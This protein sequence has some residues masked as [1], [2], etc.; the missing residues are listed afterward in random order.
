[1]DIKEIINGLKEY[2]SATVQNAMIKIRGFVNENIDYTGPE[3]KSYYIESKPVVGIAVTC[4]VT[5]LQEPKSKIDWD[6]YYN[7]I[8]ASD[9]PV[10]GVIVDIEK[11][12]GRGAV[13]GDGMALK[14]KTLGAV[15]VINGG[16]IRDV[17]GIAEV[18]M[19]VWATGRVP[20]HGPFNLI[21]T[22][23]EVEVADLIINAGD[24]LIGDTDG[25]TSIPLDI[26][27]ETLLK[28]KEVRD[29]ETKI[30]DEMKKKIINIKED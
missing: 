8:D 12:K 18:G 5:P 1:M 27:E 15:G 20:G 24:L 4:K 19:P 3:L 30:F 2:D 11:K 16:S 23:T 21:E 14:H 26:A 7:N 17:P 10:I 9:L 25:I 28:C 29:F 22:Q 6:E 13:M